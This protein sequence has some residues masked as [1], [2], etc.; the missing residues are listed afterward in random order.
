[1]KD[2]HYQYNC[3]CPADTDIEEL[4]CIVDD[5]KEITYST[6]LKHVGV[7]EFKELCNNLG[8]GK[9]LHI[10]NDWSVFYRKAKFQ[11]ATIYFL[12]QSAIEY[13]FKKQLDY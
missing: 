7:E 8:Y 1:M 11:S 4:Y 9:C 2:Y 6:F 5:N 12:V 3:V 10:K 13:V